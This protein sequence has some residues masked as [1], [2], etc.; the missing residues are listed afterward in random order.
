MNY[1]NY[2]NINPP[3][4][5]NEGG[6]HIINLNKISVFCALSIH[7]ENVLQLRNHPL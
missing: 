6:S 2:T 7:G 4:P 5:F 1:Y 3:T